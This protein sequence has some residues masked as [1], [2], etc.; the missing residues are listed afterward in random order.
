MAIQVRSVSSLPFEMQVY[1]HR[2]H[3]IIHHVLR[4]ITLCQVCLNIDVCLLSLW[5][6]LLFPSLVFRT[7][8]IY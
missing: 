3:C 1:M 4:V 6:S 8:A 5:V 2:H 7:K